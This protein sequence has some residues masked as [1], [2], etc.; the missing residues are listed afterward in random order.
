VFL[1]KAEVFLAT[2]LAVV[3]GFGLTVWAERPPLHRVTK[4]LAAFFGSPWIPLILAFLLLWLAMPAD[5][6]LK[7]LFG[8]WPYV[9]MRHGT[10]FSM[11]FY[12]WSMGTSAPVAS[13]SEMS[14]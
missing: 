12:R 8:S 9:L 10:V 2:S 11:S 7:G 5:Q 4:L 6:A 14:L 13:L 1:T 3:L